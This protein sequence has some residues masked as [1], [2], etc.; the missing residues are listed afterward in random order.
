MNYNSIYWKKARKTDKIDEN[1]L[2]LGLY[3]NKNKSVN[4]LFSHVWNNI[5]VIL[6]DSKLFISYHLY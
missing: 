2:V 3:R 4:E 6:V 1:A 5:F